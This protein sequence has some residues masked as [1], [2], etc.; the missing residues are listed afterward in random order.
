MVNEKTLQI[1]EFNQILEL[2]AENS[3]S[4]PGKEKIMN[5]VPSTDFD[6]VSRSLLLTSEADQLMY[7]HC[8]NISFAFDDIVEAMDLAHKSIML[9]CEQLLKIAKFIRVAKAAK[10]AINSAPSGKCESLKEMSS[11]IFVPEEV[12]EKISKAILSDSEVASTASDKLMNIRN[13]ISTTNRKIKEKLLSYTTSSSLSQYLQ[14]NLVTIRNNRYVIPVKTE[15]KSQVKGLIHDQSSSGA[16]TFIE[17][18]AIVDLNN[19]LRALQLQENIEIEN[20]LRN[21]SYEVDYSYNEI[22]QSFTVLVELDCIFAK[23]AYSR[24]IKGVK[25]NINKNGIIDIVEGRHPLIDPKKV[26]AVSVSLGSDYN[27]LVISGP[28]T[29]GK[30]VSIKLV[31]LL[32][33]MTMAGIFIPAKENSQIAIFDDIL[34]CIGDDQSI[35]NN[36]STFSAHLYSIINIVDNAQENMLVLLDELGSGTDPSEGS[37]LAIAVIDYLREKKT[38]SIVTSHFKE[39]KEYAYSK[40]DINIAGMD[41]DPQ[42]FKPTYKLMMGQ[43]ASSNALEIASLLGLKKEIIKNAKKQISEEHI[44]FNNILKGAEIN[45]REAAKL[46]EEAAHELDEAKIKVAYYERLIDELEVK[47]QRLDEKMRKSAR[48]VL[49]DYLVDADNMIEQI[50]DQVKVGTEKALFEARRIRSQIESIRNA[51][52]SEQIHVRRLD[53][54]LEVGDSVLVKRINK[55]GVILSIHPRNRECHVKMGFLTT[56]CKFGE[57]QKIEIKNADTY[58]PKIEV[59]YD[60]SRILHVKPE[61]KLLGQ[62]LEEATFELEAYLYDAKAKGYKQVKVIHGTSVA[63]FVRG[64]H[65]VIDRLKIVER[66][67][68]GDVSE[69]GGA[70]TIVMFKK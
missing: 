36:L 37:A 7:E 44:A 53:G 30:T 10:K 1:L 33:I 40:K 61:I 18:I 57:L 66:F 29:G 65:R 5:I 9:S 60:P 63:S 17:P 48:E 67:R 47:K 38:K 25:P 52:F 2:I 8:V 34:S 21:L 4:Y 16:T 68:L 19:E 59:N 70:V 14:D 24:K 54:P 12:E 27:T 26:V 32:S 62:T 22:K 42:T 39:L 3:F 50:K 13:S 58:I 31:G 49:D 15:Y 56:K 55:I 23:A 64:L 43:T 35:E 11:N 20:I 28:N 51:D 69:G 45:R 41:F 6:E 46:K